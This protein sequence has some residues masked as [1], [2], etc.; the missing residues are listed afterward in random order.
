MLRCLLFV[1]FANTFRCMTRVSAAL[2][3]NSARSVMTLQDVSTLYLLDLGRDCQNVDKGT[4][5]K[6]G[7]L[8]THSGLSPLRLR[9]YLRNASPTKALRISSGHGEIQLAHAYPLAFVHLTQTLCN[10]LGLFTWQPP[11]IFG[12]TLAL[13]G[14]RK[15]CLFFIQSTSP[16]CV[17][18]R[19]RGFAESF[20]SDLN[21]T[22]Q[23][24]I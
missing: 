21:A 7:A 6:S 24:R 1:L 23:A 22:S 15:R 16:C 18:P 20:K 4:L 14:T 3:E 19:D 2:S 8:N 17:P 11:R 10:V 5:F 12:V 13:R 9:H